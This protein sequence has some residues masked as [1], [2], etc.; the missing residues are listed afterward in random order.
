MGRTSSEILWRDSRNG[1]KVP[2]GSSFKITTTDIIKT[3]ELFYTPYTLSGA[4]SLIFADTT[5]LS[6]DSDG[7]I[8]KAN[9]NEI[10]V[11]NY[12]RSSITNVND[13]FT[14]NDINYV[15]ITFIDS[16][17]G[18]IT[19]NGSSVGG[20]TSALYQNLA[21]YETIFDGSKALSNFN[22]YRYGDVYTIFDLSNASIGMT[23]SSVDVYDVAW[24]LV[25]KQ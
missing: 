22:L 12:N 23:E 9:I 24:Q 4:G 11:N 14:E 1:L 5:L 8:A 15:V 10:F 17:T 16:I 21:L 25:T 3:I 7:N 6:W 19:I 18:E 2:T 20:G 13:L